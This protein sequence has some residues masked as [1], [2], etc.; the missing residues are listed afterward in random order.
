MPQLIRFSALKPRMLRA[1]VLALIQHNLVWHAELEEEGEVLEF[2]EEECLMRLRF[3]R[4]ITLAGQ[5]LG[6]AVS[7]H[8][9]T[10]L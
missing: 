3:G 7:S 8:M 9:S 5:M 2:N 1:V 6:Q 10:V 4:F